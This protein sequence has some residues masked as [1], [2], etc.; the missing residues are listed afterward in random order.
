MTTEQFM[1]NPR[2]NAYEYLLDKECGWRKDA[3]NAVT[4]K[5]F[6]E[7]RNVGYI[8]EGMDG[9]WRERWSLTEFGESQIRSYVDLFKRGV[10]RKLFLDGLRSMA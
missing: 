2:V 1:N 3:E 5:L 4:K 6:R 10:K 7:L 8:K 9:E